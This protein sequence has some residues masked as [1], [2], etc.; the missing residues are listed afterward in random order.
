MAQRRP[1]TSHPA[2]TP[3][4]VLWFAALFGLA[5]AVLPTP[6]LSAILASSGLAG[7]VPEPELARLAACLV[8]ALAGGALGALVGKAFARRGR[9]D[10]RPVFH[11]PLAEAEDIATPAMRPLRVREE[12][13]HQMRSP[14]AENGH[15]EEVAGEV[16]D[17][18]FAAADEGFM[19]LTPQPSHPGLPDG[20]L[21][22]LIAQFDRA[23]A[24]FR[25]DA[26]VTP[27]R[28]AE[29]G[30]DPVHAFVERQTGTPAPSALGGRMPDHQAELRAALEKLARAHRV[31][32]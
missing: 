21:E 9:P 28:V 25:S 14:V 18:R 13:E 8:A 4:V 12:L 16:E 19:I 17:E 23:I 10:P 22:G 20:E 1:I 24:A 30:P 31:D 32:K 5:V 29:Q 15:A 11:E 26:P 7:L 27:G 2:F 6:L 3:L